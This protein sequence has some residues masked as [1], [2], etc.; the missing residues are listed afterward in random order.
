MC[1]RTCK[2][3]YWARNLLINY[4]K[5]IYC[6]WYKNAIIL[7]LK[8]SLFLFLDCQ[9]TTNH[10]VARQCVYTVVRA[11]QQVDGK[12]MAILGVSHV[13]TSM[14]WPRVPNFIKLGGT[15]ASRQY[16]ELYTSSTLKK[17]FTGD[18]LGG[19]TK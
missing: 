18:F 8:K 17:Y 7:C 9:T 10:S 13:I 5:Y 14:R 1:H 12:C 11:T 6:I 19:S 15:R 4:S 2:R 16:G 3:S